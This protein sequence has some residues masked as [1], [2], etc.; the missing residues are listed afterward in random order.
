MSYSNSLCPWKCQKC[1]RQD[2]SHPPA[3]CDLPGPPSQMSTLRTSI[4]LLKQ[5]FWASCSQVSWAAGMD[6]TRPRDAAGTT[7]TGSSGM[8]GCEHRL[9]TWQRFHGAHL[10]P[11]T[12]MLTLVLDKKRK[13]HPP[14]LWPRTSPRCEVGWAYPARA[15]VPR[16]WVPWVFLHPGSS[17]G[18]KPTSQH[19]AGLCLERSRHP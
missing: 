4:Y 16:H 8:L 13:L 9:C 15:R 7:L 10:V 2:R 19:A 6:G 12:G 17:S 1:G 11:G 3:R 5:V 14:P 18:P